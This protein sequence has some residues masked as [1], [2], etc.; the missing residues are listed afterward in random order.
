MEYKLSKDFLE[1]T[2]RAQK[3]E[4]I[5]KLMKRYEVIFEQSR[6]SEGQGKKLF[7]KIIKEM[8]HESFRD[9][10]TKFSCF[11]QGLKYYKIDLNSPT[12]SK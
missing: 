8:I 10:N 12:D 2:L 6:L 1:S 5:G 9:L 3:L 7:K 11:S 4:L